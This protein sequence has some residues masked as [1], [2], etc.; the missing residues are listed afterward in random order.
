MSIARAFIIAALV[1]I[2]VFY[3]IVGHSGSGKR[4][5][6]TD[7]RARH[8]ARNVEAKLLIEEGSGFD[9]MSLWQKMSFL[10]RARA[11]TQEA[12][13]EENFDNRELVW[14]GVAVSG[15]PRRYTNGDVEPANR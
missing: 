2:V 15:E 3:L 11:L 14:P 8:D 4:L 13:D 1:F 7:P 6:V 10:R 5:S 12:H 9:D